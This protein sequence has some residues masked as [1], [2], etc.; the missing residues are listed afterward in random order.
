MSSQDQTA[1]A[2]LSDRIPHNQTAQISTMAVMAFISTVF[3]S[4]RFASRILNKT[5]VGR[6]DWTCMGALI[7]SYGALTMI[8]VAAVLGRAAHHI[9][10]DDA[11]TLKT[12]S[13]VVT[14]HGI[15][16]HT[17]I[18][19]AKISILLFYLRIFAISR[20]SLTAT[21]VVG[22]LTAAFW[23]AA[24]FGIIFTTSPVKAQWEL[25]IPHTSINYYAFSMIMGVANIVLDVTLLFFFLGRL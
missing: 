20:P 15:L 18:S 21:W 10:E 3:V 11:A 13:K 24:I 22:A 14:S 16:Y 25:S 8:V 23:L 1:P 19:L 9:T 17:S 7:I 5:G 12:Y 4:L 2:P 6:D